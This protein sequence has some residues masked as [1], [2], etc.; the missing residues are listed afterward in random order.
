M[1]KIKVIASVT[2]NNL[3]CKTVM[4]NAFLLSFF[5]FIISL[6]KNQTMRQRILGDVLHTRGR[7]NL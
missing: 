3:F 2:D 5:I 4:E 1:Q 7:L 6:K